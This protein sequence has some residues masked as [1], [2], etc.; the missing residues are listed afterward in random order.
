MIICVSNGTQ[1]VSVITTTIT[2]PLHRVTF[3][4]ASHPSVPAAG[5]PQHGPGHHPLQQRQHECRLRPGGWHLDRAALRRHDQPYCRPAGIGGRWSGAGGAGQRRLPGGC[6]GVLVCNLLLYVAFGI[7]I[8]ELNDDM[9]R[10]TCCTVTVSCYWQSRCAR[11]PAVSICLAV[12][13]QVLPAQ[14]RL[15]AVSDHAFHPGSCRQQHC[16]RCAWR[17]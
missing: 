5:P 2:T 14:R 17:L 1:R 12:L 16:S 8:E 4:N 11:G 3:I 9:C 15:S 7:A 13:S 10:C 6:V